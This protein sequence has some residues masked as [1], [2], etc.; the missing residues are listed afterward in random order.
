MKNKGL[1]YGKL[2]AF[3]DF[4]K[5]KNL[6]YLETDL[7]TFISLWLSGLSDYYKPNTTLF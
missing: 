7:Q 4:F 3:C 1:G 6:I 5:Q 2:D